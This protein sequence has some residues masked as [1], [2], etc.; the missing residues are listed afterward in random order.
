MANNRMGAE[1]D[2]K[3]EE[4]RKGA[5]PSKA[6]APSSVDDPKLAAYKA[7]LAAQGDRKSIENSLLISLV[8]FIV[9]TFAT[10]PTIM[11]QI[12]GLEQEDDVITVRKE[13]VIKQEQQ[14]EQ[15]Q[16][17]ETRTEQQK[18]Q[19]AATPSLQRPTGQERIVEDVSDLELDVHNEFTDDM[20]W[21]LPDELPGPILV[22]GD[23]TPPQFIP[24]GVKPY[25]QRAKILRRRGSVRISVVVTKDG[26]LEDIE[27][28][29]ENPPDF[30]FGDAA[31][32]Y[33][34]NGEWKPAIQNGK[35][36]YAKYIFTF[37]FQLN[38]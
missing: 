4:A 24:R 37:Q 1:K 29:A 18:R 16:I 23:I 8:F 20:G 22:A 30:G 6:K 21:D 9:L 11:Q 15:K 33:L 34:M 10:F 19:F 26:T 27:I 13:T 12:Q 25:P 7:F 17:R 38:Q 28:I 36:I 14:V 31:K 35:P 32:Q 2:P 3:K 5:P